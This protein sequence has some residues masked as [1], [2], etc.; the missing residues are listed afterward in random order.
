MMNAIKAM[1]QRATLVASTDFTRMKPRRRLVLV[2]D[3]LPN[4]HDVVHKQ[5]MA[6]KGN[7]WLSKAE[8]ETAIRKV[9]QSVKEI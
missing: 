5:V 9:R 7:K 2:D 8:K 3:G 1:Q 6:I 4:V